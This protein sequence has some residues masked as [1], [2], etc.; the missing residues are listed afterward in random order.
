MVK[1]K[2]QNMENGSSLPP[3]RDYKP[4]FYN[5]FTENHLFCEVGRI[6]ASELEPTELIQK[7]ITSISKAITFEE[8]SVYL[9]KNDL[10]G[11]NPLYFHS[12][13][14]QGKK[15]ESIYLDNGAPGEMAANGEPLFLN[16][17][18]NYGT[19]LHHPDEPQKHGSYI[20][21][22]LKNAT[23][24]VGVMGFS[25]S[26]QAAFT[27]V[28]L[29]L[30]RTLSNTI[31]AG[32]EKADLFQKTMESARIDELTGMFNYRVLLEKLEEEINRQARTEKDF[33]IIMIDIDNFKRVNDRYGHL[34]GSRV[35][36]QMGALLRNEFRTGTTDLCFRYG[37]EEFTILLGE[38][39]TEVALKVAERVR[40]KVEEYPFTLKA[41]HPSEVLTVSLGVSTIRK[42]DHKSISELIQQSDIA[43]YQ[44]KA[45][46]K[47]RVTGYSAGMTMPG[48]T[49]DERPH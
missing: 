47:N 12:S 3:V 21:I 38:S 16:D 45:A 23:R 48:A 1:E 30:L 9:V 19:F 8:A 2:P 7:I 44:S 17:A 35:I 36:A 49:M 26:K 39:D 10:T 4:L 46:G 34:E 42:G 33:S 11:L 43:L 24:V 37:G 14:L 22:P 31:S 29:D 25:H 27:V 5:K 28:D 20:G 32:L 15:S 6:I 41:L 13:F 18:T 40:K